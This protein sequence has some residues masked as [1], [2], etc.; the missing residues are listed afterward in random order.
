MIFIA[1]QKAIN[2][3][4]TNTMG[5]IILGIALFFAGRYLSK[6]GIESPLEEKKKRHFLF[7]K[8]EKTAGWR[9]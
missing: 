3:S 1:D 4:A 6:L 8:K 5:M 2:F 9:H 7:S